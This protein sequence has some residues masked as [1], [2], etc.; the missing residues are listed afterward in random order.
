MKHIIEKIW[1][2]LVFYIYIK[3]K[4]FCKNIHWFFHN[5]KSFRKEL[6]KFRDWDF[7]YCASIFSAALNELSN[8]LLIGNE[9]PETSLKKV[10]AIKELI[11]LIENDPEADEDIMKKFLGDLNNPSF[12]FEQKKPEEV[13]KHIEQ[14][15]KYDDFIKKAEQ[16]R[17]NRI[18]RIIKGQTDKELD[19]KKIEEKYKKLHPDFDSSKDSYALYAELF[20]GTGYKGWWD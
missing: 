1:D 10:K 14:L 5:I 18:F 9:V 17:L 20:D 11:S 4:D 6:W 15:K 16:Q 7:Y 13:D 19:T 2:N 8:C 3:P 12:I